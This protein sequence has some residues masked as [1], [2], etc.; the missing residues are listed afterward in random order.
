LYPWAPVGNL[1]PETF[2][3]LYDIIFKGIKDCSILLLTLL[4]SQI[5]TH[6]SPL[7]K[8]YFALPFSNFSLSTPL[9]IKFYP[10]FVIAGTILTIFYISEFAW[11]HHLRHELP[12]HFGMSTNAFILLQSFANFFVSCPMY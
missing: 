7:V 11:P 10:S 5:R 4:V 12:Y 1:S 9:S 3:V 6:P 8:N 2:L